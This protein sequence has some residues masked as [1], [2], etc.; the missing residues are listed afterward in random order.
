MKVNEIPAAADDRLSISS[1]PTANGI[2]TEQE[3]GPTAPA[4][5]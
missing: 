4:A 3:A 1:E 2:W 5:M